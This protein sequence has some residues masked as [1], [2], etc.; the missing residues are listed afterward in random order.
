M[1]ELEQI[2]E[3]AILKHAK[4]INTKQV[5]SGMVAEVGESTCTVSRDN[6][7]TLNDVRLNS[8]SGDLESYLTVYP[9]VDSEVLVGIIEGMQTE[10]VLLKCSKIDKIKV[11]IGEMNLLFDAE[12]QILNDGK[13]G[14][15]VNILK[16]IEWMQKVH[17]D[18]QMLKTLLNTSIVAGNGAPLAIVFNP[19]TTNPN[20]NE[21]ED[22]KVKH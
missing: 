5:L 13:N 15:L 12:G 9:A 7:P 18:L 19:T 14:G 6:A 11:R 16:L 8:I 21:L 4:R 20:Q 2:V 1:G 10:A 3:Q 17:T 22:N